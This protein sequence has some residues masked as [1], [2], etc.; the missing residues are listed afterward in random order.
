MAGNTPSTD[1]APIRRSADSAARH[2]TRAASYYEKHAATQRRIAGQV[3]SELRATVFSPQRILE[4]GCGTGY[5]T[6]Q[7]ADLYPH[8]EIIAVDPA[9]ESIELG[10]N[11]ISALRLEPAKVA[12]IPIDF[13]N[14]SSSE[15]FDLIV[16]S[17]ALQWIWPLNRTLKIIAGLLTPG[18]VTVCA[19][20][21]AGTFN[22]LHASRL[23]AAP[24]KPPRRP[25]PHPLQP[26][27]VP[28][29]R[30]PRS[31]S[32]GRASRARR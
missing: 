32:R 13:R 21:V 31:P 29:R 8:A 23:E 17:S 12:F 1:S 18:G 3:I 2:F 22:E 11:K 20:I 10:Q 27:R 16:S 4:V 26:R 28:L 30:P 7:L 9:A 19:V 15:P 25:L 24:A 5:L 6:A 14:Y